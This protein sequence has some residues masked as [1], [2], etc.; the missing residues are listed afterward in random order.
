M[1]AYVCVSVCVVV[2]VGVDVSWN[3][4]LP[5][6]NGMSIGRHGFFQKKWSERWDR[7]MWIWY[8]TMYLA[9]ITVEYLQ[10]TSQL[11][12]FSMSHDIL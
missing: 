6:W 12:K 2:V 11:L 8:L 4:M 1:Y 7:E 9:L 3:S 10:A 5:S